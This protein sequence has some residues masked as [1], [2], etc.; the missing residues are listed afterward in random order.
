VVDRLHAPIA[1]RWSGLR[2]AWCVAVAR[3]PPVIP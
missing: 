1:A 3:V 2:C